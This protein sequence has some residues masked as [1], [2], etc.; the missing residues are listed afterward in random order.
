MLLPEQRETGIL[1][2]ALKTHVE[3]CKD[4][5]LLTSCYFASLHALLDVYIK[6]NCLDKCENWKRKKE[7]TTNN[8]KLQENMEL[9]K[10]NLRRN[11][12][13]FNCCTFFKYAPSF[14]ATVN[15]L[16]KKTRQKLK[17][18]TYSD[19]TWMCHGSGRDSIAAQFES[20]PLLKNSR[21]METPTVTLATNGVLTEMAWVRSWPLLP[22]RARQH[23][24]VEGGRL[25][26]LPGS[27]QRV[28]GR[29]RVGCPGIKGQRVVRGKL[30]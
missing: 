11:W 21:Q 24:V 20:Q 15:Q 14:T 10:S 13:N 27:Q 3:S 30:W 17:Y 19:A 25:A 18:I 9:L 28:G 6:K 26:N 7:T 1:L 12:Q 8:L 16:L 4:A 2:S 23:S 5:C 22:S 29:R